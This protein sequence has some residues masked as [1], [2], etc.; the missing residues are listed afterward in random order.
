MDKYKL[1]IIPNIAENEF[2]LLTRFAMMEI[3]VGV[4]AEVV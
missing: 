1:K 2:F 4:D 3:R